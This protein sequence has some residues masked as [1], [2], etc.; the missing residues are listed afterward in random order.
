VEAFTAVIAVFVVIC[1]LESLV[2]HLAT[3]R[4]SAGRRA[5][6]SLRHRVALESE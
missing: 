3:R 1:L 6:V 2:L 5:G 4:W